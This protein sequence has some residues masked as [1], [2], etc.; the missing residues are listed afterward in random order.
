VIGFAAVLIVA[1][2][3]CGVCVVVV[4][5]VVRPVYVTSGLSFAP[6]PVFRLYLLLYLLL[7][8]EALLVDL[9]G[10]FWGQPELRD[11]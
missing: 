6:G 11:A 4:R 3:R 10:L 2:E 1:S 9:C 5:C 8:V 7:C